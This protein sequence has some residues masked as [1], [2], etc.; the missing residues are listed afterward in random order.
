MLLGMLLPDPCDSSCPNG[1]KE[2]AKRLLSRLPGGAA[3]NDIELR[4]KLL[5]FIADFSHWDRSGNLQYIEIA[6]SLIRRAY[7]KEPPIVVDTFSGGGAIPLEALRLGS[8][9]YSSDLNPVACLIQ[10]VLLEII[11]RYGSELIEL[12][13]KYSIAIL[14]NS[15]SLTTTY[16]PKDP[17]GKQPKAYFWARTVR[18]E[19]PNCGAEI[20]V[21][22][23]PWLSKKRKKDAV[24][25][26]ESSD[27][28]CVAVVV[29]TS[30]LGG[31]LNLRVAK[32]FGSASAQP[33]F[34]RLLATKTAGNNNNVFCPCCGTVLSGGK[35]NPRVPSQQI[36]Q[37]GGAEVEF[38]E[39]GN[40]I[41][42]ATLLAVMVEDKFG[43]REFRNP[44]RR[45]YHPALQA[46]T[47]C[48]KTSN[49]ALD[50]H[51]NPIRPSPNARGL[52]AVTRYGMKT[53]GNLFTSRQKVA[54][55]YLSNSI[56]DVYQQS[57]PKSQATAEVLALALDKVVDFNASLT[58][59]RASNEDVAN[60]FGRQA[61]PMIWDFVELNPVT[62]PY[63]DFFRAVS[64]MK[65]V[66]AH[67]SRVIGHPGQVHLAD[68]CGTILPDE[69]ADI[70]FTDPPYYDAVPYADLS[71][72]FLVWLKQSLPNHPLLCDP[73]NS[74]NSLSPKL[75]ECVWNRS[76]EIDGRPKDPG[77][78]ERAVGS[79]FG[80]GRALLRS[81][82]IGCVIFAHKTTEGWEALL[83]GLIQ[84]RWVITSSWPIAT[85]M[86]SRLL[87]KDTAALAT[88]VHLICHPRVEAEIGDWEKVLRE[89]PRRVGD[90]MER[91]QAEGVR[92]ADLVF[93][94]IGPALEIYSRYEKVVDAE[95]R[96]IP[97]GGDPEAREPH[98]RGYLAYVWEIVGRSALEQ[99]LGTAEANARNGGAGAL[100]EDARLTAL[101]LWTLQS[102]S[103]SE[104]A[105]R[106]RRKG[107]VDE[108]EVDDEIDDS[109]QNS[110]KKGYTL[111]YDVARR[112]AQPLGIHLEDWE[113]RIIETNKGIV[114]LLP[115]AERAKQLFGED[116]MQTVAAELERGSRGSLQMR[117]FPELK[118]RDAAKV[119]GRRG[120]A[121]SQADVSDRGMQT[122][123]EPTTLDRAHA[124]MLL[125][126]S[127][128]ANALRALIETEQE[129]GPDFLRLANALS[130]LYP[131]DSEEKRLLDAMLLAVPR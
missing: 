94:C 118:D 48:K 42:G 52:S 79:A 16:Y 99:V 4:N 12:I 117:L 75:R 33:G 53:F 131:K 37:K 64:H 91:L 17:D 129:R 74:E 34:K 6:R 56:A 46:R 103:G 67:T 28:D 96:T 49:C 115:I 101:F 113:G 78:F 50:E 70:F 82:G 23:S 122:R 97:L 114:R 44:Q 11:P 54:L 19:A 30:P 63:V 43:N 100:E 73:F 105:K 116:G 25:F 126:R 59:W 57:D 61:L 120:R 14:E 95:E 83:A 35:K 98:E 121:K 130:A 22:R 80:A 110:K 112:F 104:A 60:V 71:D 107:N 36:L 119:R 40:R 106:N 32:G 84:G 102:T 89:L 108:A 8:E 24:V 15:H 18:C 2:E 87:A 29:D 58:R 31:P 13:E 5:T 3:N 86:S 90:W 38:D 47:Q 76:Y 72:F 77:F 68:A 41:G 92:G 66:V 62:S 26:K 124:A 55:S 127:G 88:S 51:L 21:F 10:K 128:R 39:T 123:W 109:E 69:S 85:E 27:G 111:V 81:D 125:Q 65:E 93:A 7:G 9:A 1:F 45:D 20:P